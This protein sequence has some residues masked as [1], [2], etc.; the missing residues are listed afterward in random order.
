MLSD[1]DT[2]GTALTIEEDVDKCEITFCY[3]DGSACQT[4]VPGTIDTITVGT[5]TGRVDLY[6]NLELS[7]GETYIVISPGILRNKFS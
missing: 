2:V 5:L 3:N 1:V 4:G 7:N 6:S